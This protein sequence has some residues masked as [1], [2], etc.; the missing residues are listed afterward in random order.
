[1]FFNPLYFFINNV[2]CFFERNT[3]RDSDT[4]TDR[5]EALA[6][7]AT[8]FGR[9]PMK[10]YVHG[11]PKENQ[12]DHLKLLKDEGCDA[13][14]LGCTEIPLLLGPGDSP[15]PMLDSTRLLA[16]AALRKAVGGVQTSTRPEQRPSAR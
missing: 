5:P 11:L 2:F 7:S 12:E 6:A 16:L 15:L 8:V 14:V 1:M 10:L 4:N 9:G 13:V 3:V